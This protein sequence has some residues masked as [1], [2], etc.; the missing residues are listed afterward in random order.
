MRRFR[1]D[2]AWDS[3]AV[4]G[5]VFTFR[6]LAP[7]EVEIWALSSAF[8]LVVR[9]TF[10]AC[11][12]DIPMESHPKQPRFSIHW[13]LPERIIRSAGRKPETRTS[14]RAHPSIN[15]PDRSSGQE[16]TMKRAPRLR[17]P[18]LSPPLQH[19]SPGSRA[20][21]HSRHVPQLKDIGLPGDSQKPRPVTAAM[22]GN[23]AA[24]KAQAA[25]RLAHPRSYRDPRLP[26]EFALA[27]AVKYRDP[28]Q[29]VFKGMYM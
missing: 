23:R 21:H 12:T 18:R 4:Q 28:F 24:A 2:S 29:G 5:V 8:G 15:L 10:G 6:T 14:Q 20:M 22:A 27:G 1:Q 16:T 25:V 7:H 19:Q 11:H 26:S 9:S 17:A 3:E 13:L